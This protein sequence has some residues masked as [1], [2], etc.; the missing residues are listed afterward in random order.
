MAFFVTRF[1]QKKNY[2]FADLCESETLSELESL[3]PTVTITIT[4][5]QEV[6]K[7]CE[8]FRKTVNRLTKDWGYEFEFVY[9]RKDTEKERQRYKSNIWKRPQQT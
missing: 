9:G 4:V 6:C 3:G 2:D 7:I 8:N 5:S 1:L